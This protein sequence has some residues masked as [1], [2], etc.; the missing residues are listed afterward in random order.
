MI[1][2]WNKPRLTYLVIKALKVE[3]QYSYLILNAMSLGSKFTAYASMFFGFI[4][5][6]L[7]RKR[8]AYLRAFT[9]GSNGE[10]LCLVH[11]S[12]S[13]AKPS[14]HQQ[15]HQQYYRAQGG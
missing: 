8:K 7:L 4:P 15:S 13:L 5:Y 10:C 6:F 11:L 2:P 12:S 9:G 1:L 3:L 14:H